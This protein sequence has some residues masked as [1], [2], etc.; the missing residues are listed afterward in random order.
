MDKFEIVVGIPT[1]IHLAA[2]PLA[3]CSSIHL[4]ALSLVHPSVERKDGSRGR[5]RTEERRIQLVSLSGRATILL[6][7]HPVRAT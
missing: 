3:P 4:A 2:L 7:S 1:R 6:D 5:Q